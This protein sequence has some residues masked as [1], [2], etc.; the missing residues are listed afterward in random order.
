[1]VIDHDGHA[2]AFR[3]GCLSGARARAPTD[4][5]KMLC[6]SKAERHAV[7][8]TLAIASARKQGGYLC[9]K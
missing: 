2:S 1:M 5:R 6:R 4:S 9:N 7:V 3:S 8:T